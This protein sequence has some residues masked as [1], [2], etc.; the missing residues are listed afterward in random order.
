MRLRCRIWYVRSAT[1]ELERSVD[2]TPSTN[3]SV[4]QPPH[5][6]SS[7]KIRIRWFDVVLTLIGIVSLAAVLLAYEKDF[8]RNPF[9]AVL[10]PYPNIV[11]AEA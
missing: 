4:R 1:V 6:E 5:G 9:C 2:S 3:D 11:N 10:P 7:M 8:L